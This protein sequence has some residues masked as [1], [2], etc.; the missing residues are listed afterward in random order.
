MVREARREDVMN[1]ERYVMAGKMIPAGD[2]IRVE[3]HD[4]RQVQLLLQSGS[5]V[6]AQQPLLIYSEGDETIKI[7]GAI[8]AADHP[9]T[10]TRA[11]WREYS[12]AESP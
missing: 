9:V 11:D 4:K 1:G 12:A 6:P 3:F 7:G 10:S 5:S 2:I 8:F